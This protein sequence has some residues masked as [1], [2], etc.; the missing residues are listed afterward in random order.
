MS[1]ATA[2]ANGLATFIQAI[3]PTTEERAKRQRARGARLMARAG[4]VRGNARRVRMMRMAARLEA[5]AKAVLD[6]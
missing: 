1:V 3:R 6:E 5:Q 2:I 4:Y